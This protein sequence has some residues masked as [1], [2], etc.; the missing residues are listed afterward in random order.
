MAGM[1]QGHPPRCTTMAAR[2]RGVRA[3]SKVSTVTH[4][5]T[6]STSANT[7]T[8]LARTMH[9][10]VAAKLRAGHRTSQL[11]PMPIPCMAASSAAVPLL[12]QMACLSDGECHAA[13]S[14]SKESHSPPCRLLMRPEANTRST[15]ARAC[16]LV[17][18]HGGSGAVIGS[19]V[20]RVAVR[21]A[22]STEIHFQ[23]V[24]DSHGGVSVAVWIRQSSPAI[25]FN[26]V[27]Q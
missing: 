22:S 11:G 10:A 16:G 8:P 18:G 3:A 7:G 17:V 20:W 2:V 15:A 13:N 21:P 14:S 5:L 9:I 26:L 12:M 1:S 27:V 19:A 6:E 23:L 25:V 24:D 4:P